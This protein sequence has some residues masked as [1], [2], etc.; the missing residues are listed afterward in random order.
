MKMILVNNLDE[1][2]KRYDALK[3]GEKLPRSTPIKHL[4]DEEAEPYLNKL[5]E[6]LAK[7][8]REEMETHR[9]E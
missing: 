3:R 8:Y 9:N 6:V 4:S 5:A 1:S 7:V 2:R